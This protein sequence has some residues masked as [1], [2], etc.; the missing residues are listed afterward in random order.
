MWQE[1]TIGAFFVGVLANSAWKGVEHACGY[2]LDYL[3]KAGKPINHDLERA[4]K[5]SFLSALQDIV[6][7][8]DRELAIKEGTRKIPLFPVSYPPEYQKDADWLKQKLKELANNVTLTEQWHCLG[9]SFEF[10][11]LGELSSLLRTKG[12][13]AEKAAQSVKEKLTAEALRDDYLPEYYEKKVRVEL[14]ERVCEYFK[15]EIKLTPSI[16]H[17][18]NSL[19]TAQIHAMLEDQQQ[20]IQGLRADQQKA[21]QNLKEEFLRLSETITDSFKNAELGLKRLKIE[22][23]ADWDKFSV[24]ELSAIMEELAKKIG[25]KASRIRA[26]SIVLSFDCPPEVCDRIQRMFRNG[27]LSEVLGVRIKDVRIEPVGIWEEK[28]ADIKEHLANMVTDGVKYVIFWLSPLWEPQL[29]GQVATAADIPRQDKTFVSEHGEIKIV[30]QWDRR[31]GNEPAYLLLKW[32]VDIET[33]HAV[34]VRLINPDTQ[35]TLYDIPLGAIRNG[36]E[37]FTAD[38]LNFD[39][40]QEKWAISLML[41]SPE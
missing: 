40:S 12:I 10:A 29:A 31:V 28:P 25:I 38:E 33:E 8:C 18:F 22:L 32:E 3:Q 6:L 16:R 30:C 36:E 39:P 37:V 17:V 11:F 20:E 34:C 9:S 1:V 23:D 26:G 27:E 7:E 14:F 19:L 4:L 5:L 35:E 15:R 21:F 41:L 24:S 13:S 2:G